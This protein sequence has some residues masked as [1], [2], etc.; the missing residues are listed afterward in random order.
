MFKWR[1]GG[2]AESFVLIQPNCYHP[3]RATIIRRV[4]EGGYGMTVERVPDHWHPAY[5]FSA[6]WQG[7]MRLPST[8]QGLPAMVRPD[9]LVYV[10]RAEDLDS[11]CIYRGP[12][13]VVEGTHNVD[14]EADW[15]R[16]VEAHG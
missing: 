13:L 7:K 11:P 10:V 6:D 3:D 8:R 2:F 12:G 9:G 15:D 14:T 1:L 5:A 16:L 4:I